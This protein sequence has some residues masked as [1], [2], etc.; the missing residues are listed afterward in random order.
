M[1]KSERELLKRALKSIDKQFIALHGSLKIL[2][3]MH[4]ELQTDVKNLFHALQETQ[5]QQRRSFG[6]L[7]AIDGGRKT[8]RRNR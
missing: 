5:E 6:T 7:K 2:H 3:N 8:P 1:T 4:I